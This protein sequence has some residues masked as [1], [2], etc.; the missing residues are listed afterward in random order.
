MR[1]VILA[2][3]LAVSLAA[4][5]TREPAQTQ[6]FLQ[7]LSDLESIGKA[8]A[9][10]TGYAP[11]HVYVT[12]NRNALHISILEGSLMN[13]D[14]PALAAAAGA[15]VAAAEPALAAHAE[16]A[17]VQVISVGIHHPSGLAASI[18][19]WHS[20]NVLEFHRG[21]DQRFVMRSP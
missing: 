17:S 5:N 10:A 20:E 15:V 6:G 2:S 21:A 11:D 16:F 4:C 1:I 14:A 7:Y 13:A 19:D 3:A 18:R 9:A 8:I 12:G